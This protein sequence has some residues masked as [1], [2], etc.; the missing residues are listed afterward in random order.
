M[1]WGQE[2]PLGDREGKGQRFYQQGPL[3]QPPLW[4]SP[5]SWGSQQGAPLLSGGALFSCSG[6][7]WGFLLWIQGPVFK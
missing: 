5:E 4:C 7:G 2:E 6:R 3:E 1:V